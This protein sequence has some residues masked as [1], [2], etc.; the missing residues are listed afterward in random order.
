MSLFV[1]AFVTICSISLKFI[2][3]HLKVPVFP[4]ELLSFVQLNRLWFLLIPHSVCQ[5][6]TMVLFGSIQWVVLG[7]ILTA[8]NAHFF[9]F[10]GRLLFGRENFAHQLLLLQLQFLHFAHLSDFVVHLSLLQLLHFSFHLLFVDLW[11]KLF[12]DFFLRFHIFAEIVLVSNL[13][14]PY[15]IF[16]ISVLVSLCP[17]LAEVI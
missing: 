10:E 16:L 6:A 14:R 4:K 12:L 13:L 1:V 2:S 15:Q 7:N 8:L 9:F 5:S 3:F 11:L 17:Y